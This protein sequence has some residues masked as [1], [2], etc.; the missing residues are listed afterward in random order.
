MPKDYERPE[1]QSNTDKYNNHYHPAS[2]DK[3]PGSVALRHEMDNRRCG[4]C[5]KRIQ[6]PAVFCSDCRNDIYRRY[7][8]END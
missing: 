5:G 2:N 1:Y 7:E 3:R 8:E 6:Y 4:K